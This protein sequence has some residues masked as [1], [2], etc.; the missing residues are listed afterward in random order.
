MAGNHR[1]ARGDGT[2]VPPFDP[3]QPRGA[4]TYGAR[5]G[6]RPALPRRRAGKRDKR[7]RLRLDRARSLVCHFPTGMD[8]GRAGGRPE[9]LE[10]SLLEETERKRSG[11]VGVWNFE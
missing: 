9:Q 2:A 4:R 1:P 5:P 10:F 7:R 3:L 6:K 11:R 8:G